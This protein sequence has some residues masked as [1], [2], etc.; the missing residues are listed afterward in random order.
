MRKRFLS[1]LMEVVG[2]EFGCQFLFIGERRGVVAGEVEDGCWSDNGELA[3]GIRRG[4]GKPLP[5]G[6]QRGDYFSPGDLRWTTE[7]FWVCIV[8]RSAGYAREGPCLCRVLHE[9]LQ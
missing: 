3:D 7:L 2:F 6:V 9:R 1:G 4:R 5:Y 8:Y